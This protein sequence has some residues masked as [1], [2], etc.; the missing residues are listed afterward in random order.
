MKAEHSL[1]HRITLGMLVLVS[2]L[3][4]LFAFGVHY[5]IERIQ[6][7]TRGVTL[8]SELA[9]VEDVWASDPGAPLPRTATLAVYVEGQPGGIPAGLAGL[10]DGG[11]R[12][13]VSSERLYHVLVGRVAG[14]KAVATF[15]IS[16]NEPAEH[17][18]ISV[19]AVASWRS[20]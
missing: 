9:R 20:S 11:H 13:V 17:T 15:D 8:S 1:K 18:M 10:P 12:R 7:Y 19:L 3:G 14:R 6:N 4:T 5:T 2:V 16:R